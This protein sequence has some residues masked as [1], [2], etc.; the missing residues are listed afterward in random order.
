MISEENI[1]D[2]VSIP[3]VAAFCGLRILP[4]PFALGGNNLN[5]KLLLYEEHLEY[6]SLFRTQT[7]TYQEIA[8]VD[9]YVNNLKVFSIGTT[10]IRLSFTGSVFTFMG[11]LNDLEKLKE[12]L[13]FLRE[14]GCWLSDKAASLLD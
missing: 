3:L 9:V 12:V 10:N 13:F 7:K 14:K 11:N 5:P 2:G 1:K 6:K 8:E 4:F